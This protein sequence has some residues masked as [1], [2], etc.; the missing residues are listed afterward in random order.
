MGFYDSWHGV[1]M[2]KNYYP[3]VLNVLKVSVVYL[4]IIWTKELE[5][6]WIFSPFS[7]KKPSKLKKIFHSIGF[8]SPKIYFSE[9]KLKSESINQKHENV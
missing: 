8:G 9:W 7:Q 4:F 5:F 3:Y 6:F 1:L 2:Y